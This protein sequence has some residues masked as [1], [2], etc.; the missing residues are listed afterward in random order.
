MRTGRIGIRPAWKQ[1][2]RA[3]L[4]GAAA[5]ALAAAGCAPSGYYHSTSTSLDSL[6]TLQSQQQ[7]RL[8]ALEREIANTRESVQATRASSDTRLSEL[9]Q[10]MDMMQGKLEESGMRFTAL[11]QKMESVK[12]KISSSD[13]M[14]I[15]QGGRRDSTAASMD[16]EEA[17]QAAYSDLASGRYGL[18]RQAFTEYLARYPDTE[19][20]DNA[21]YWIGEC[22]YAL[23]DFQGAIEAFKRV[24]Q[25]YPRGDKVP[26]A[27]L[28]TGIAYSRLKDMDTA[29]KYY[30]QVIQK[31]PRSDEARL[32]RERLG[33]KN[34][35]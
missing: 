7:R 1:G 4:L 3:A 11:S 31:Y 32:A 12:Q 25:I 20:S 23:G 14:R 13:S 16:P 15:A 34:A 2:S 30:A 27:L 21:Q 22:A 24:V 8:Q 28:K 29:K 33:Q 9:N 18:A 35:P 10:R 6:V 17:Y 26:A 19:V 5:I